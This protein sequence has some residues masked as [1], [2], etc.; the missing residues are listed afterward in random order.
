[1]YSL[2][3]QT[4]ML[5]LLCLGQR[6]NVGQHTLALLSRSLQSPG[7]KLYHH[8]SNF[9]A[10]VT[11]RATDKC[12]LYYEIVNRVPKEDWR[13]RITCLRKSH[14]QADLRATPSLLCSSIIAKSWPHNLSFAHLFH[15]L[16]TLWPL[17]EVP[18]VGTVSVL[19]LAK[20]ALKSV[21]Q[22]HDF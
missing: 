19:M 16:L 20:A 15:L 21:R 14:L 12:T 8:T 10:T 5:S 4:F 11:E 2:L 9:S 7:E 13:L 18:C 6:H 22:S 3:Q 1:M 17:L